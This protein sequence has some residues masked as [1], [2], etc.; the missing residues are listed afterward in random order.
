MKYRILNRDDILKAQ[1]LPIK[2]VP[3]PEWG[4]DA[5]VRIRGLTAKERDEFE[6]TAVKEDFSGVTKAGMI[7]FRA[8]LVALT[9]IDEEGNNLF[10]LEDAEELGRKSAQVL[11][12]LF[13]EAR[14]LSGF[15]K[16][17]VEDLIKN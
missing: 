1:D 17:D 3:V 7:N 14:A 6:L 9:V 4:E 5:A 2:V 8:K 12:R 11:D 15:T 16:E 10:S 13:N